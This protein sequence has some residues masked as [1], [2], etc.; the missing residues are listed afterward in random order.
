[1]HADDVDEHRIGAE[2]IERM[3]WTNDRALATRA[4]WGEGAP[5]TDVQFEDAVADPL[6]QVARVYADLGSDLTAEA[7]AAMRDWL[8]RRPRDPARPPYDAASFGLSD[9]LVDDRFAAYNRTF[10]SER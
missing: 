7:E 5:V 1:M 4:A 8:A 6:G 3:G 2:W 10:R 9:E